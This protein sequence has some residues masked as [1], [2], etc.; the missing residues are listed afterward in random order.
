MNYLYRHCSGR[1]AWWDED[2]LH[3]LTCGNLVDVKF[4]ER[5][6]DCQIEHDG[7]DYYGIRLDDGVKFALRVGLVV[8]L[9]KHQRRG[10]FDNGNGRAG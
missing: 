10:H 2:G 5:W 8:R 9:P 1:F 4:L 7:A 3:L 6:N